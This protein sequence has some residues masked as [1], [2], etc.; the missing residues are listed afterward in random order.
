MIRWPAHFEPERSPVFVH[1]ELV[2]EVPPEAVWEWLIRAEFWPSWYSNSRNV[3]IEDGPRPDLGAGSRFQWWTFGIP[4][5]FE[6]R[7]V[8]A[9]RAAGL[10]GRR[11]GRG[12]ISRLAHRAPQRRLLG[13]HRGDPARHARP[14]RQLP[15]AR[16][17]AQASPALARSPRTPGPPGPP[18]RDRRPEVTVSRRREVLGNSPL[19]R[20]IHECV[21]HP[22]EPLTP[23]LSPRPRGEGDHFP[24]PPRLPR[25]AEAKPS[26]SPRRGEGARRADEGVPRAC[27]P[28]VKRSNPAR[29]MLSPCVSR[30][31]GIEPWNTPNTRK[32]TDVVEPGILVVFRVFGVFRGRKTSR[33]IHAAARPRPWRR[34]SLCAALRCRGNQRVGRVASES[35]GRYP[36]WMTEKTSNRRRTDAA[37]IAAPRRRPRRPGICV[38]I[39]LAGVEYRETG[40]AILR[41]GGSTC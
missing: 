33:T 39:D 5:R 16:S 25:W 36:T 4:L 18:A 21:A 3:V 37:T 6:R 8:R 26:P 31:R 28:T 11:A 40:V 15:D 32:K 20:A 10:A 19:T 13:P 14:A 41:G 30:S 1:N 17:H 24:A 12:R 22:A 7:G 27:N 38:G 23:P 29:K 34:S 2:M 35:S 9:A